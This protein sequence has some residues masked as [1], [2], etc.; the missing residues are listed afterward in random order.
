MYYYSQGLEIQERL[1]DIVAR[2]L[3]T[4]HKKKHMEVCS[5]LLEQYRKEGEAFLKRTV[6]ANETWS[7]PFVPESKR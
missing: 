1:C 4:Q 5:R 7:H 3:E 2:E 6:T